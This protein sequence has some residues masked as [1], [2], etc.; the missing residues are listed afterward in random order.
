MA[1]EGIK[2]FQHAKRKACERLDM[3][4]ARHLPSN[5]EIDAE[6]SERLRIF[7]LDSVAA[8]RRQRLEVAAE[9]MAFLHAFSPRLVGAL[10]SGNVV[11]DTT[12]ELHLFAATPEEVC[13]VLD[14]Q[15]IPFELMDKRYRFGRDRYKTLPVLRISADGVAIEM[16]IFPGERHHE[17]PLSPVDGRPMARARLRV[18]RE[19]LAELSAA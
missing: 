11:P 7:S 5:A 14:E 19:L 8:L 3:P 9:A 1:E 4:T 16:T 15:A 17:P 10:L 18:V 13:F 12:V 6:L 2:D